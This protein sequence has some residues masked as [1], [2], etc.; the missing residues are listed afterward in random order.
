MAR[1]CGTKM[2]VVT[3]KKRK[4]NR[5]IPSRIVFRWPRYGISTRG[6]GPRRRR[7]RAHDSRNAPLANS[8]VKTPDRHQSS[9]SP[10]SHAAK[11]NAKPALAYRNPAKLGASPGSF[12]GAAFRIPEHP[13]PREMT[14]VPA[15]ERRSDVHSAV[16]K[17]GV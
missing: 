4:K 11:I 2:I 3:R 17:R 6:L 14:P 12:V 9:L 15:V 13:L 5:P 7:M 8:A 10:C 1:A 16:D